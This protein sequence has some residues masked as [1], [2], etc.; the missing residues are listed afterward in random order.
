MAKKS[1]VRFPIRVKTILLIVLFGL[2]LGAISM[3]FF[4]IATNNSNRKN[5]KNLATDLSKTVALSIDIEKVTN[6]YN[7]ARSY[8]DA[9]DEKPTRDKEG[10]PEY[11]EYM[12]KYDALKATQDYIDIQNYLK[13]IKEANTDTAGIY[14]AFVDYDLKLGIYLVYD[15]ENPD[16]PTGIIDAIYEEDYQIFE[17]PKIGFVASIYQA[18]VEGIYLVT[19]GS[20]V[21][22]SN[23]DVIC[24]ALVDITM[25]TV[26]SKLVSLTV[27]LL[28]YLVSTIVILCLVGA[29]VVEFLVVRPLKKLQLT[30]KS[31]NADKPEETH[32]IFSSL[33]LNSNDEF[34]DLADNMKNMENDIYNKMNELT[35]INQQLVES[36]E[37]VEKMTI[38]ANKDALTGVG[39]KAAYD[40]EVRKINERIALKEHVKFG[41][42]MID[43][44]YLKIINDDFGH[45]NGDAALKRLCQIICDIFVHSPVFRVGGDEFVV[46]V[47]NRDYNNIKKL[48]DRFN[49]KIDELNEQDELKLPEKASAAIGYSKYDDKVDTCVDD[50]FKRADEAMYIRKREM[51]DK[52]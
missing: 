31:Y 46:I 6:I 37:E 11:E 21:L 22:D 7:Q 45:D 3:V 20:P 15:T 34:S 41:I 42:A 49:K 29:L 10:T 51:K 47:M 14:I 1:G 23:G 12:A 44:N 16:Y 8:Y 35:L 39:S 28:V 5:Y 52:K 4:G 13:A 24:Y 32:Q 50:V 27:R 38:L 48:I 30:A 26:D 2:V 36:Q 9:Y 43:L 33:K 25:E 40:E 18:E 17:D 19:A